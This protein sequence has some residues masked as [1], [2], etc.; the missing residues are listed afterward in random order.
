MRFSKLISS[1]KKLRSH[2]ALY[3]SGALTDLAHAS[4]AM[5][6]SYKC[7]MFMKLTPGVN[8]IK[9]FSFVADN[10]A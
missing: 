9:L 8:V 10:K 5:S 1:Q 2:T 4:G 7:K 6:V 3:C